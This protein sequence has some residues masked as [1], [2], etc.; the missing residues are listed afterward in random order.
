MS[1]RFLVQI[2]TQIIRMHSI[3]LVCPYMPMHVCR[4][5]QHV[6]TFA[7]LYP[8]MAICMACP[9]IFNRSY[10]YETVRTWPQWQHSILTTPYAAC[11]HLIIDYYRGKLNSMAFGSPGALLLI[12]YMQSCTRSTPCSVAAA[13]DNRQYS[14]AREV[15]SPR[16]RA[17]P[18]Y[19]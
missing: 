15:C 19:V 5:Y 3:K 2:S 13:C 11:N 16:T 6:H 4:V 18:I 12:H 10:N 9:G 8:C 7:I 17:I 1:Q 14:F